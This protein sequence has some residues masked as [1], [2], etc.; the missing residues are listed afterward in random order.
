MERKKLGNTEAT[1]SQARFFILLDTVPW[2][3]SEITRC[4]NTAK[5]R[6]S[7]F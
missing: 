2:R 4:W 6:W 7:S 3:R 5:T 1:D